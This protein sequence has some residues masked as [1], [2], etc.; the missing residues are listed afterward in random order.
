[1]TLH[2][3]SVVQ[4]SENIQTRLTDNLLVRAIFTSSD[5]NEVEVSLA[6]C[7]TAR[8]VLE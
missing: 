1:V 8:K 5:V 6:S 4:Y 7:E 3:Q 2:N